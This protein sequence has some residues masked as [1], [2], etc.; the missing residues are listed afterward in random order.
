M[1]N[2]N[3]RILVETYFKPSCMEFNGNQ[4]HLVYR[5]I[6]TLG[7]PKT[8]YVYSFRSLNLFL[9]QLMLMVMV[10]NINSQ[11]ENNSSLT[12]HHSHR[13]FPFNSFQRLHSTLQIKLLNVRIKYIKQLINHFHIVISII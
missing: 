9:I 4:L 12:N 3:S 10:I 13:S 8:K 1:G 6:T 2:G 5:I 7:S 11:Y